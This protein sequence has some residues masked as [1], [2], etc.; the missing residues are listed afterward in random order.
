MKVAIHLGKHNTL[1][2]NLVAGIALIDGFISKGHDVY[3]SYK[4]LPN[5]FKVFVSQRYKLFDVSDLYDI[6]ILM[7][8]DHISL[9]YTGTIIALPDT[10][11]DVMRFMGN[12]FVHKIIVPTLETDKF[13]DSRILFQ[14]YGLFKEHSIQK[15]TIKENVGCLLRDKYDI[16]FI[17]HNPRI[18]LVL[19]NKL[20]SIY[21]L[22]VRKNIQVAYYDI[23]FL[24]D[25][26][27]A[28]ID[29]RYDNLLKL[30]VINAGYQGCE[31]LVDSPYDSFFTKDNSFTRKDIRKVLFSKAV[32][33]NKVKQFQSDCEKHILFWDDLVDKIEKEYRA[34]T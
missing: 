22:D 23:R 4:S 26:I 20:V 31:V 1:D 16:N 34:W 32:D 6:Q 3:V 13:K 33:Q 19:L 8:P 24:S 21:T 29:L 12:K 7:N 18:S 30:S 10:Y 28:V 15:K 17:P 14:K 25:Y 2:E 5:I 27:Q 9:T 11:D